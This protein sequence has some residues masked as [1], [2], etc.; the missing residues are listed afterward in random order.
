MVFV[1]LGFGAKASAATYH[2]KITGND[3]LDGLSDATAWQ[4]LG[5]VRSSLGGTVKAGDTVLFN[6]GD[7]FAGYIQDN[8]VVFG[9]AGNPITFDAYGTGAAPIID[10]AG[11]ARAIDIR[12][13]SY[14]TFQNLTLVNATDTGFL[15]Y[16]GLDHITLD[17]IIMSASPKAIDVGTGAFSNITISNSTFAGTTSGITGA[18]ATIYT[19]WTIT[20]CTFNGSSGSGLFL[21][22]SVAVT[23]LTISGSQINSNGGSAINVSSAVRLNVSN[24]SFSNNGVAGLTVGDITDSTISG[25]TADSNTSGDGL[26]IVGVNSNNI[27]VINSTFR[28][29]SPASKSY[30]G[31]TLIGTGS[32]I[33]FTNCI[34]AQNGGDGFNIHNSWTNVIFDHCTSDNNG[35]DG[36]T[37]DGDG[38]SFHE[39]ST[40]TIRYSVSKNNKKSAVLHVGHTQ[41]T[42]YNNLFYNATNGTQPLVSFQLP[43]TSASFVLYNNV[44]WSGGT[45]GN[46]VGLDGTSIVKNNIVVGCN[47]GIVKAGGATITE[48]YNL[49]YGAGMAKFSGLSAGAHDVLV[50]PKF[51]N[52]SVDFSLQNNSPAIDSGTSVGLA[53]D[54]SGNPIY[55]TPDI[56][57]YEYQPPYTIG[58]DRIDI[59]AGVR[60]YADGQFRDVATASGLGA[61]LTIVPSSGS[62]ESF[63]SV[64]PRPQWLDISSLVWTAQ[65]K[66][67]IESSDDSSL[68]NILHTI[69]DL[70]PNVYYHIAVDAAANNLFGDSCILTDSNYVCQ[71]D[72]TGRIVFTYT[73]HYSTHTFSV[74]PRPGEIVTE[75]SDA[76]LRIKRRNAKQNAKTTQILDKNRKIFVRDKHTEL[77]GQD[78]DLKNG[79]IDIYKNNNHYATTDV[80]S[81]GRWS[82]NVSFGHN[83]TY[84]LRLKFYD[85]F[86]TLL[87]TKEY[88]VEIDTKK[89][90]F[91]ENLPVTLSISKDQQIN[92]KATDDNDID[93][94]KVKIL[95]KNGHILRN[96]KQNKA[97][98][99]IP[100]TIVEKTNTIIVRAYD[101]AGNWEEQRAD[102]RF[103][104]PKS[105]QLALGAELG[106]GQSAPEVKGV[107]EAKEDLTIKTQEDA[108]GRAS[109]DTN[110]NQT[111]KTFHWWNP[112]SWF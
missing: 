32:N 29:N 112:W 36:T 98:Y 91:I 42:H 50:D 80:N 60:V 30:N 2:V 39:A 24:S 43:D 106:S 35:I 110:N 28:Y 52:P 65:N 75:L 67:W 38:F 94:Y 48:D 13:V 23:D 27:S 40:G 96:K 83:K 34:S 19:T 93:Y 82:K 20:N 58:T 99:K 4:T 68:T 92:F 74:T 100:E 61:D 6:R 9:T 7:T 62:F 47:Y 54:Y 15:F 53:T 51:V 21:N 81:D 18:V 105:G 95:D 90:A 88:E 10:A 57:A 66:T 37:T 72:S 55:G 31:V 86:G 84:T 44:I 64:E 70:T 78:D 17:H 69:G 104:T 1:G 33:T 79:T 41:V 25:L 97:W 73:G 89:P 3:T 16:T 107:N 103:I 14:L 26:R 22:S 11:Q 12:S 77:K 5:K 102:I 8:G 108:T 76:Q 45:N 111:Q 49:V 109:A 101:K 46:C 56:G 71:A 63:T 85:Q 59:G 87:N